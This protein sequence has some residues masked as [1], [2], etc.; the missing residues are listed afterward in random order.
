MWLNLVVLIGLVGLALYQKNRN[1][2]LGKEIA[3]LNERLTTLSTTLDAQ[4]ELLALYRN[5]LIGTKADVVVSAPAEAQQAA[6][7]ANK[8]VEQKR[9]EHMKEEKSKFQKEVQEKTKGVDWYEKEFSVGLD[10]LLELFLDVP[11][12]RQQEIIAKMP[13]SVIK[14]GFKRLSD[15]ST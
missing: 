15:S 3:S 12:N 7:A 13:S 10:A 4:K 5:W 1:R 9:R 2:M 8:D 11:P 14:K 6:P